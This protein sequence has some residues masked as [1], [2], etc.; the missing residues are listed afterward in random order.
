MNINR[1]FI[2][3]C[4][5]GVTAALFG[6]ILPF[7]FSARSDDAVMF[8]IIAV[9]FAPLLYAGLWKFWQNTAAN[10]EDADD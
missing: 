6:F 7:L 4:A 10:R 2:L 5:V 1:Y 8:G 9:V 3:V